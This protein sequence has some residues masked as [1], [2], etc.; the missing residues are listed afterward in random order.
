MRSGCGARLSIKLDR[1]LGKYVAI[2]FVE[3]Q[4]HDLVRQECVHMLPSQRKIS[5]T[6]VIEVD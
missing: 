2:D 4:N 1:N 3:H 5:T 6:Q